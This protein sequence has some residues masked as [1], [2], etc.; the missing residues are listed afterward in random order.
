MHVLQDDLLLSYLIPALSGAS[1]VVIW[2][3][4]DTVANPSICQ[5]AKLYVDQSLGPTLKWI[6]EWTQQ[7]SKEHCSGKGRCI[8]ISDS[9]KLK[10]LT[11]VNPIDSII[12]CACYINYSGNNC[13]TFV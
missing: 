1:G 12:S 2:G 5:Q 4:T 9:F 13:S 3:G 10:Y 11:E 7:C 8:T 6:T